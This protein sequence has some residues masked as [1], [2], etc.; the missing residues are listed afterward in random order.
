MIQMNQESN[1]NK[2]QSRRAPIDELMLL[3]PAEVARKLGWSKSKLYA[4]W[5]D[6]P[7]NAP[8]SFMCGGGRYVSAAELI[9]WIA[10][11]PRVCR[12]NVN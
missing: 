4:L 3:K 9:E 12:S 11:R 7:E 2:R 6:D 8:P 5:R 10:A 1:L